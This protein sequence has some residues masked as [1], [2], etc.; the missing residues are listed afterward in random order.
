MR[1]RALVVAALFGFALATAAGAS[2]ERVVLVRPEAQDPVLLDAWNRLAAELRIHQFEIRVVEG[3]TAETA[4]AALSELARK[5]DALAAIALVEQTGRTT[6]DVWLVDRVSGK[7]TMRT[8][9]VRR[10][11][12]ASSVLAIRA[13]DL[14]RASLR[15]FETD[16]RPPPDIVGV[17]RRP[18][19]RAAAQLSSRPPPDVRCRAEALLLAE[20]ARFG[21]AAGPSL[22]LSYRTTDWL[23]LG[24]LA[25]GPLV[26]AKLETVEGSATMHQELGL[27]EARVSVL[28]SP[29]FDVG[30]NAA[31]GVHLLSAEGQALP[32]LLSKSDRVASFAFAMGLAAE[33][34]LSARIA[35]G[36]TLRAVGMA[37]RVGVAV[38]RESA[39]LALPVVLASGGIVVG[40]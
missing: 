11:A 36:V 19:P 15:E 20:G 22:G 2:P 3:G 37:P 7:T 39:V 17:D 9:A 5:V 35:L 29:L 30:V 26:G 27:L 25:S 1:A 18:V 31:L 33:V 38:A 4:P 28:R 16:E 23:E 40:L 34:K 10:G 6:V 12:D 32:P 21:V 13:V 14:L 24:I 8:I